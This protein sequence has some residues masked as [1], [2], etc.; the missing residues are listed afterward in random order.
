MYGSSALRLVN[1]YAAPLALLILFCFYQYKYSTYPSVPGNS[2]QYPLGWWGWTD[3]GLYLKSAKAFAAFDLK[4]GSHFYPPLYPALGALF[5]WISALHPF[6]LVDL[7]LMVGFFLLVFSLFRRH[8]GPAPAA[9]VV[10]AGMVG[11][12]II[13]L[14]W[15][16]PWTSTL[17]AFLFAAALVLLDRFDQLRQARR[18]TLSFA[19]NAFLFGMVV[20]AQLATRPADI[21]ATAAAALTYAALVIAMGVAGEADT[22]R[23]GILSI[24]AGAAGFALPVLLFAAFNELS[25]GTVGG[26]Y[27]QVVAGSIGFDISQVPERLF[28]LLVASQVYFLEFN[29]DWISVI[30][31]FFIV[32]VLAIVSTFFP[33]PL[34]I[35]VAGCMMAVHLIVYASYRDSVPT[36]MFRFFN[37]HYYKWMFPVALGIVAYRLRPTAFRQKGAI[38]LAAGAAVIVLI[39][40]VTAR[41]MDVTVLQSA[42]EGGT[43]RLRIQQPN[44]VQLIDLIGVNGNLESSAITVGTSVTIDGKALFPVRDYRFVANE[45]LVRLMLANPRDIGSIEIHLSK[46]VQPPASGWGA[47]A[48]SMRWKLGMPLAQ[49]RLDTSVGP[50]PASGTPAG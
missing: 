18:S 50:A 10:L 38:A 5:V 1:R 33:A 11:Y 46:N 21:A 28:S 45:K 47:R 27:L 32:V 26:T 4:P 43:V 16:V 44:A 2:T 39:T 35:R 48:S 19:F 42:S 8:L 25:A 3:Q 14:Q 7:G 29:A 37:V 9:I 31:I 41:R 49:Q 34:F 36:G 24:A 23:N 6:Y 20:G 17:S 12:R 13:G 30:P 40:C 15:V 22:R